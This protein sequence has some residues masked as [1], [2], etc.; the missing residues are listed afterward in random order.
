[1]ID[2][3]V[4]SVPSRKPNDVYYSTIERADDLLTESRDASC[5]SY[6]PTLFDARAVLEVNGDGRVPYPSSETV[7]DLGGEEEEEK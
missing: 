6:R 3:G 5:E 2:D 1:M 4:I 7:E